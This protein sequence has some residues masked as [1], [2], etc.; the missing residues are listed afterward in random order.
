MLY[1]IC[2][3]N[4]LATKYSTKPNTTRNQSSITEVDYILFL[5]S[6][7]G[8]EVPVNACPDEV[9]SYKYVSIE[10]LKDMMKGPNLK[11]SPWFLGIME[12]GGFDWWEDLDGALA[13]KYTN[14]NVAF[15][16]PPREHVAAY[17]KPTHGR[18]TGVLS[19]VNT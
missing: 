12:R 11:W 1:R 7:P 2:D 17:N 16:D 18:Q 14:D 15:F 6:P 4:Q 10:E 9:E 5:K 13:G 8:V 3:K 19:S